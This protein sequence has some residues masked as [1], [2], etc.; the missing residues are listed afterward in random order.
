MEKLETIKNDVEKLKE[1][2]ELAKQA[3]DGSEDLNQKIEY[4]E[5]LGVCN[6]H[7]KQAQKP[8]TPSQQKIGRIADLDFGMDTLLKHHFDLNRFT[9]RVH[10][11][12]KWYDDVNETETYMAPYFPLIQS[13]G[14]GKTKL[15]VEFRNHLDKSAYS[16][17][18][19][20]CKQKGSQKKQ[21]KEEV[22]DRDLFIDEIS[23]ET[24][25]DIIKKLQSLVDSEK[26]KKVVLLFDESQNLLQDD[27]F[28][29]RVIRWWLKEIDGKDRYVVAVFAGTTSRLTNFYREMESSYSSRNFSQ[30]S[31]YRGGPKLYDP[32]YDLCTIGI[33]SMD[34]DDDAS[35]SDKSEFERAIPFGRP[36]F[37]MMQKQSLLDEV[38]ECGILKRMLLGGKDWQKNNKPCLS[39]LATRVQMG[40]TSMDIT[41]DLVAYGYA[42]LTHYEGSEYSGD[43]VAQMCFFPDPVCARL[44]MCLMDENWESPSSS[45][46]ITP[47]SGQG[48]KFW[49]GQAQK[50]FS[51]GLCRPQKGDL[52]EVAAAL[53]LLFCGDLHRALQDK[54]YK[55]FSVPLIDWIT[56]MIS[57]SPPTKTSIPTGTVPQKQAKRFKTRS[58]NNVTSFNWSG[59]SI[60]FIQICRNYLRLSG[61]QI[62]NNDFLKSMYQAGCAF[63]AYGNC[64]AYD[65]FG[66]ISLGSGELYC[67]LL[68]SVK[69]R[70]AYTKGQAT[71]ACDAMTKV[72]NDGKVKRGLCILLLL[73]LDK[74]ETDFGTN[75]L[76]VDDFFGDNSSG[77]V[78]KVIVV[79]DSDPF[80]ITDLVTRTVVGGT[81][82]SEIYA[83]HGSTAWISKLGD[84]ALRKSAGA[85]VKT[86]FEALGQALQ[87]MT[88]SS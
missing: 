8:P 68:V 81:E 61:E 9:Q 41:S 77:I 45:V 88:S 52:G 42:N 71:S 62:G 13:S 43:Q 69:T 70:A 37:A 6:Y 39:I 49:T 20:L 72:L 64:P 28:A 15:L 67:P 58:S 50:F 5:L 22:F 30:S 4:S 19:I 32:F 74:G 7:L 18:I 78:S 65:I 12:F 17:H 29:C 57:P 2:L 51:T 26:G 25:I 24:R 55:S 83:S 84:D 35:A 60:S 31:S 23:D 86:Y 73:G 21:K 11:L 33:F 63:Y 87:G 44:A 27:G 82:E 48:K 66:S 80:G 79:P 54:Q 1:F 36:L 38:A 16:C 46:T 85:N 34:I 53:Y 3:R 75:K 76:K 56:T 14:M 10:G 59:A 40:Q 47:R